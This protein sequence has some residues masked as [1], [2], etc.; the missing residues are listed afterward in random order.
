MINIAADYYFVTKTPNTNKNIVIGSKLTINQSMTYSTDYQLLKNAVSNPEIKHEIGNIEFKTLNFNS[1]AHNILPGAENYYC[2]Y[3]NL[4]LQKNCS[5]YNEVGKLG[6]DIH[7]EDIN[8]STNANFDYT[9]VMPKGIERANKFVLLFHGF[10]EKDWTKYWPWAKAICEQTQSAVVLFPIAFHMQRTPKHW[11]DKR[12]MYKLSESRKKRFPN[13][14]NSTLF[15]VAISMRLHSMP[16]RFI[17]SGLQS[18]YDVIQFLDECKAGKNKYIKPNFNF[19]IFGYSIGGLLAQILKFAN[20]KNYFVNT[21]LVM[22]CSGATF[23]R[24]SPV[25]KYI[26]DSEANVAL[27]S[28][29]IEHFEKMLQQDKLLNH[30][31]KEDHEEGKIFYSMLDYQKGRVI[32]EQFLKKYENQI[33]AISLKKDFIFPSFEIINNLKG[34]YRDINIKVEEL[35]Y[36]HSYTHEIPFPINTKDQ[37]LINDSFELTFSKVCDFLK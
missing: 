11:S 14:V 12:A 37:Q 2:N 31:I 7:I 5:F 28:F 36:A 1:L 16:Q 20:F 4:K 21:K 27:Y 17:W 33:Y 34:A 8:V 22:Y 26:L 29:L 32:R 35:D 25:S 10:N 23:N 9:I 24:L 18:Y 3:H 30:Y 15:N 13:V 6:N 19:N